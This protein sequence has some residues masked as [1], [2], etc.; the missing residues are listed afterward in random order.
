MYIKYKNE[1]YKAVD[2]CVHD[3]HAKIELTDLFI[4]N[5]KTHIYN[6]I[7]FSELFSEECELS[8]DLN[9]SKNITHKDVVDFLQ[10]QKDIEWLDALRN[11]I[12]SHINFLKSMEDLE[13]HC[14][15]R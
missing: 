2:I 5:P 4:L 3:N 14:E 10:K 6:Y 8:N 13:K 11:F 12:N 1:I 7:E 15:R 9:F